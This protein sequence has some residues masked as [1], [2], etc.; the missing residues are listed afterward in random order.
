MFVHP[1]SFETVKGYLRGLSA[2]LQ[3]AGIEYTWE[4]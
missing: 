3:F 2:G 4:E 1:V